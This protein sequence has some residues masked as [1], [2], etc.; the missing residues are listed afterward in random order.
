V[1]DQNGARIPSASVSLS[2]DQ[3]RE[4]L[5]TSVTNQGEY[6]FEGLEPGAYSLRIEAPGFAPAEVNNFYIGNDDESR[7]DQ[8]LQVE[9]IAETVNV[10]GNTTQRFQSMGGAVAVVMPSDPFIQAV[11]SDDMQSVLSMISGRDVNMRDKNSGTTALEHATRNANREM[12][13]LLISSG[14]DVNA[15]N[16][17]GKSVLMMLD[18]DATSDLLWELINAGAKVNAKD[19]E[20]NTPLMEAA[21]V[22]N[23][24]LIRTLLEAGAKVNAANKQGRT[25]LMAA[26][27]EGLVNNIRALILAG[28]E[29][30]AVDDEGKN[31][32]D[33]AMESDHAAVVRLLRSEGIQEK[34]VAEQEK[35]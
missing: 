35:N 20:G 1:T 15:K 23:V 33:Y 32:L 9:S 25:A 8:T 22:N 14:A 2:N 34:V 3:T 24:D 27:S 30:N 28:S 4:A 17:A 29:I 18:N 19:S 10:Q 7:L 11:S 26:A 21:G 16:G 13:Q 31:A 5:Y 12:V 6:R